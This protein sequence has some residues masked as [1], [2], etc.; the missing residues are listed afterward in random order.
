MRKGKKKGNI[1][2]QRRKTCTVDKKKKRSIMRK[3]RKLM[4]NNHEKR[5]KLDTDCQVGKR[6]RCL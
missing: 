4:K 3:S 6:K 1:L 5:M 2:P